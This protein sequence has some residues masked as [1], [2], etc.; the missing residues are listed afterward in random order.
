MSAGSN[1]FGGTIK[2]E[3]E[4]EYKKALQNCTNGL[5]LLGSE[6]KLATTEFNN[7]G[8]TVGDLRSKNDLLNK[9]VEE[10]QKVIKTCSDAVKNF[11]DQQDKNKS[12]IEQ[13]KQKLDEEKQSLE[14]MRNSTTSTTSE[15]EKQENVVANLAKELKNAETTYD[16]NS[17]KI[18][19]YKVKINNAQTEVSNLSKEINGNNEILSKYK[20]NAK[21]N[22]KAIKEFATEEDKAG[23]STLSLA[24][25]IKGNL[26]SEGIIAGIKGLASAAKTVGSTLLNVG[27]EALSSY[28]DY[29]QLVGG[30]ETLFKDSAGVVKNYANNAYKTSG[31]SA[32]DYME[33]VTSFSASLLSSLNND[34]TK[35]AEVADMAITD[36]SDNAN[37]MGTS[38]ESIQN[39]YQGFAKQNY[40]MLDNLKLGYGGTKS[41]MERLLK[42]AQKISGVKYDINN[43]S[44]VYNAIHVIQG[45]L[46]ITGTTAKEASTTIQGSVA[47]AK[48][49][50]QNLLTGVA[51][52]NADWGTLVQNFV[53][54]VSVAAENILP[55][56]STIVEGI[57]LLIT[58]VLGMLLS[59]MVP[60]GVD[61]I[62][63]LITGMTD[64]LP[65]ILTSLNV[66]IGVIL[67]GFLSMLPQILQLGI[68]VIVSLAQGLA[69]QLPTLIPQI[70]DA[71]IMMVNT[72]LDNIDLIIDAGIQLIIG[73]AQGLIN[74]LPQL[75]DRLPEIIDKI[76]TTLANNVP[77]LVEAGIQLTVM[78]AV[79]LVKAI[80]QLISKIPQIVHSMLTAYRSYLNNFSDIGSN[81]IKGIADGFNKAKNYITNKIKAVV[82][83][84][85]DGFKKLLGIHSP[86]TWARDMLG[87]NLAK[88][89]GIGFVSE[90]NEVQK[91]MNDALPTDFNVV[92]KVTT[93]FKVARYDAMSD[94][95]DDSNRGDFNVTINNNSKY[96][97]PA[98][99]TRLIRQQ[100]E[101]YKLKY[102]KVGA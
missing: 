27:K 49:A 94:D 56:I 97:S 6:L 44:D 41:E 75:I 20:D 87:V 16:S 96:T 29:E 3:G 79:G 28:A 31:L 98:E 5:K 99:N 37:K 39:A 36:M 53:N 88:G 23:N 54:S 46:D 8:K 18:N 19:D 80:P 7:N 47:A 100:Y 15:I 71:V 9:K 59:K 95:V 77:K 34:T 45:E 21:T 74:A 92:P 38:M 61:L 93:G 84:I 35:S 17:R 66:A 101:L 26:I 72:L 40:T 10:Q 43:L 22:A 4:S 69:Q 52:D 70:V 81:I 1:T 33:T 14:K 55:R 67:N 2:L 64:M 50:W 30:V 63:N 73:L 24:D 57:G 25:I 91:Q 76:V 78:L 68:Q 90:M 82:N 11:S 102:G 58:D 32:N 13:L 62:Q 12:I 60:M 51:D 65:D 89:I 48:S 86:S 42:D 83:N 85:K